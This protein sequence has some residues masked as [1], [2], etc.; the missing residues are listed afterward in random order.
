MYKNLKINKEIE[1]GIS[2]NQ[3]IDEK[4][5]IKFVR[6]KSEKMNVR[7]GR[8]QWRDKNLKITRGRGI[9]WIKF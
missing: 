1:Q 6:E 7:R 3:S 2:I 5:L 9:N 4:Q 8:K